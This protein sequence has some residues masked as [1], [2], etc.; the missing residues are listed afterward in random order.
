VRWLCTD[1]PA[2]LTGQALSVSGG[3]VTN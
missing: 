2:A 1:A 3:E